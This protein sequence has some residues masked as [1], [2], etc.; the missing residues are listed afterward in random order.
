MISIKVST[1]G[2]LTYGQVTLSL[3]LLDRKIGPLV[4][5]LRDWH[6][7]PGHSNVREH[8]ST[9]YFRLDA[10]LGCI[11]S[12]DLITPAYIQVQP[13]AYLAPLQGTGPTAW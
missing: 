3:R 1:V 13:Q 12:V 4:T 9:F 11:Y 10:P 2:D 7:L 5:S 8:Y 6:H